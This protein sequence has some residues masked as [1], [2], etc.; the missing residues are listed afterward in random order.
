MNFLGRSRYAR[1]AERVEG[2]GSHGKGWQSI[3][4]LECASLEDTAPHLYVVAESRDVRAHSHTSVCTRILFRADANARLLAYAVHQ[5][6]VEEERDRETALNSY[7][8][9][10]HEAIKK[11]LI[12]L[13]D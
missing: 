12:H 8:K 6:Y 4:I 1:A 10:L 11:V 3:P 9:T 2:R 5:I 7:L 13:T